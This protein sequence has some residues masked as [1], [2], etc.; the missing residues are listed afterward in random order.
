MLLGWILTP[1]VSLI[2]FVLIGWMTGDKA[3]GAKDDE[4]AYNIKQKSIVGSWLLLLILFVVNFIFNF[5]NL[6]P[7]QLNARPLPYPELFYLTI[8]IIGYLVYYWIYSKK[9]SSSKN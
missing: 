5:F 7:E 1:F 2:L 9:M 4:R 6:R 3:Y 8:A